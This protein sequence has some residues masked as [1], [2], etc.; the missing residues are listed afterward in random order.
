MIRE[1]HHKQLFIELSRVRDCHPHGSLLDRK[2][3]SMFHVGF[4]QLSRWRHGW[5]IRFADTE[6]SIAGSLAPVL[7]AMPV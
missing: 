4:G 7:I 1:Y 2:W 6:A 5:G 3:A